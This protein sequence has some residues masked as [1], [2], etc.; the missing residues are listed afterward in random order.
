[1]PATRS[2]ALRIRRAGD[3]HCGMRLFAA[4]SAMMAAGL[5]SKGRCRAPPWGLEPC[6][7]D[8][9]AFAAAVAVALASC[10]C[11]RA[12]CDRM[13]LPSA[14]PADNFTSRIG[15]VRQGR[16]GRDRRQAR[17]HGPSQCG[18]VQGDRDQERGADRPGAA[19]RGA[20][21][22]AR[23]EDPMFGI[24]VVPFL[25]TSVPGGAQAVGG[26]EAGD[27]EAVRSQG[28]ML[29]FAVPWPPQGIYSRRQISQVDDMKG[30]SLAR[31]TTSGTQRIAEIV[32]ALRGRRSRPPTCRRRWRP[33]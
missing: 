1:M 33:A 9:F 4:I 25:A 8:R 20:D 26:V 14:Y 13:S 29:L 30:L 10:A 28:L 17:H 11:M 23:D 32:G 16:C 3:G 21:L 18:A 31:S 19:G 22:A 15:A 6:M 12:G 24:D 5:G 2:L 7:H 27:R